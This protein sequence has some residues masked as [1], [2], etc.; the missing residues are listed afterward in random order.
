MKRNLSSVSKKNKKQRGVAVIFTLGIL[1][2]LTVMALGF[3]STALLNNSLSKNVM[4]NAYARSLAKTLALTQAMYIIT[5]KEI[6]SNGGFVD[7]RNV[8][9]WGTDTNSSN[10]KDSLWKLDYTDAGVQIY[11]YEPDKTSDNPANN[12]RWQYV[13]DTSATPK[14]IGRYAYVVIPDRGRIDPS[15][16][17]GRTASNS[18]SASLTTEPFSSVSSSDNLKKLETLISP[19]SAKW[20][21]AYN[22][23]R[24]MTFR[25]L[26]KKASDISND[27]DKKFLFQYK[28]VNPS[29]AMKSPEAYWKEGILYSRFNMNRSDWTTTMTAEKLCGVGETLAVFPNKQTFIPWLKEMYS[30]S[31]TQKQA[32]QIAANI[33]QYQR[34]EP[35][36]VD[37]AK[38]KTVSDQAGDWSN[39]DNEAPQYAGIGRH[40]M[41]NEI[42]FRV[43]VKGGVDVTS[44]NLGTEE[45][46]VYEYTPWYVITVER[47]VELICPFFKPTS[48]D[49]NNSFIKFSGNLTIKLLKFK[50]NEDIQSITSFSAELDEIVASDQW[51]LKTSE[52]KDISEDEDFGKWKKI[53]LSVKLIAD[54]W[55]ESPAYTKSASFWKNTD[56]TTEPAT[57]TT[58]RIN[59]PAFRLHGAQDEIRNKVNAWLALQHVDFD[60]GRVV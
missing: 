10:H 41:L 26:L 47:G 15:I 45:D 35:N 34:A 7:Y 44:V 21:S 60:P 46:P 20:N 25:E 9:I 52:P 31:S 58:Q 56:E 38:S 5:D 28:G 27:N 19:P 32:L 16:N 13:K 6:R 59:L 54:D 22:T 12:V 53:D 55:N 14:I 39:T 1:G 23:F 33:I 40:P 43:K 29:L 8:Y 48:S 49:I 3:A 50:S 42:G 24:W 17:I 30:N 57:S 2:L 18:S 37:V 51:I 11:K 4:N 36:S